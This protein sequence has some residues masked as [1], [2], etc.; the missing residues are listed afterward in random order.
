MKTL[1]S[2]IRGTTFIPYH[3]LIEQFDLHSGILEIY[4]VPKQELDILND[5]CNAMQKLVETVLMS[6][7]LQSL[8]IGCLKDAPLSLEE[9]NFSKRLTKL[10]ISDLTSTTLCVWLLKM[11]PQMHI[12]D[13]DIDL[14]DTDLSWDAF[15]LREN[16]LKTL[17]ATGRRELLSSL[18]FKRKS[19]FIRSFVATQWLSLTTLHCRYLH[20]VM[21]QA[22]NL[23]NV[24]TLE[25]DGCRVEGWEHIC[26]SVTA[27]KH[28][29][30][31]AVDFAG[32]QTRDILLALPTRIRRTIESPMALTLI[33]CQR[34]GRT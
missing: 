34:H 9:L 24:G 3:Q 10:Q 4:W 26:N 20:L 11:L 2:S 13:L 22:L 12:E 30:L 1:V 29:K 19:S 8:Y 14:S 28:L 15:T 5:A 21:D 17:G 25:L 6:R 23:P 33:R 16:S 32:L 31:H 7:N 27:L 18:N